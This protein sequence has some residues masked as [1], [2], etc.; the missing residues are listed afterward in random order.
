MSRATRIARMEKA[1]DKES[2]NKN[3]QD[4]FNKSKDSIK[5]NTTDGKNTD[6]ISK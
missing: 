6:R 3:K 4:S 5:P 1:K 2:F